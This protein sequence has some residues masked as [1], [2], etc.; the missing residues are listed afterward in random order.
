MNEKTIKNAQLKA[1]RYT[2]AVGESLFLR[3]APT[4]LKS[5]VLRYA[6]AGAVKDLT[7]GLT[8][9]LDDH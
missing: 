7:L 9:S 1:K 3:V 4:G 5:W 8:S 6:C 2:I